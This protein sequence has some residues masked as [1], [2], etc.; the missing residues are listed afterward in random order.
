MFNCG[1]ARQLIA[2]I[3][4]VVER[5]PFGPLPLRQVRIRQLIQRDPQVLIIYRLLIRFAPVVFLPAVNPL[6]NAVLHV[7]RIRHDFYGAF[8]LETRKTFDSGCQ[9]HAVIGGMGTAAVNL[10]VEL[11]KPKNTS[12]ASAAGITFAGAVSDQAY[13]LQATSTQS[14]NGINSPAKK[15]STVSRMLR[16]SPVR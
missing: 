13:L 16:T 4:V 6:R 3:I 15:R 7:F 12:P 8:F 11:S 14:A 10:S 5:V 9:F 2:S 1:V